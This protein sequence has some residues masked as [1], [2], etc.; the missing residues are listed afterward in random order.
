MNVKKVNWDIRIGQELARTGAIRGFDWSSDMRDP[1]IIVKGAF[2]LPQDRF[3]LPDV[4]L[5]LPLPNNLY[6][7][8]GNN[9]LWFYHLI[10]IDEALRMRRADGEWMMIPRQIPDM[11][12]GE[13][14]KGWAF[15]C[16]Y[17]R[18]VRPEV[19]IRALFPIVQRFLLKPR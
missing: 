11:D 17:P 7:P 15:L 19:D 5:K 6:D 9:R 12:A 10:F 1:W 18:P 8:A 16:V 3:T 4:N 13:A 2:R 14:E